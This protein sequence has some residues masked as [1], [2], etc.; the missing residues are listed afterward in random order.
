MRNKNRLSVSLHTGDPGDIGMNEVSGRRY[1]RQ[2]ISFGKAR[3]GAT[4]NTTEVYFKRLPPCTVT[5]FA[6]FLDGDVLLTGELNSPVT[7]SRGD[8][9][10]FL[11]SKLK[12]S[13]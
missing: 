10:R 6:I 13:I 9:I 4:V 12:V 8:A 1:R 3:D 7:V 5:H 11:P 2:R